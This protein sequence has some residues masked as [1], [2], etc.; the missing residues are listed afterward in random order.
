MKI[1]LFFILAILLVISFLQGGKHFAAPWFLLCLTTFASYCIVLLNS[2]NWQVVI[3]ESF[4]LYLTT[5]LLFFGLGCVL[6]ASLSRGGVPATEHKTPEEAGLERK[7]PLDLLLAASV[8]CGVL[9][10]AK[11]FID[12]GASGSLG[13]RLRHIYDMTVNEDYTPGFLFTQLMEITVA[14]AYVNTYRLM[15][16]LYSKHDRLGIVRLLIP[17]AVFLVVVLFTTDRNKFLRY[18]IYVLAL[19]VFFYRKNCKKPHPNVRLFVR[20]LI[21]IAAAAVAFFLLGA[22]KQYTSGFSRAIG[23]YGGSGLY[24]FNLWLGTEFDGKLT[25]GASTFSSA[26]GSLE[27]VFGHSFGLE[28]AP[29]F[30]R[31]IVFASPNGYVYSSNIY[32][33]LMPY[34]QDFG[35][36]GVVGVPFVTG[37]FFQFLFRE[38]S[39]RQYGFAV[40]LYCALVYQ[41][42]FYPIAEQLFRRW[43]LGIVYELA[44]LTVLYFYACRRRSVAAFG[45]LYAT[46]KETIKWRRS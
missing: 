42:V 2:A 38:A 16:R 20:V 39:R 6:V 5:A 44:W 40:V 21:L 7:Y 15:Q 17:V 18:A 26:I 22:A 27:T 36:F 11:V 10:V 31:Y 1:L 35:Y 30:D 28:L 13:E 29:R 46:R 14:I 34:V 25:F 33:A 3:Y 32:S 8:L 41:V 4:V 24:N 37:M 19:Y 23:I 43:T 9:Y 12:S 45:T